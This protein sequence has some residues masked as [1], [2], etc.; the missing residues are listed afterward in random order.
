[1][2]EVITSVKQQ[3]K[4]HINFKKTATMKLKNILL[5]AILIILGV[6]GWSES[7]QEKK[8]VNPN[9]IPDELVGSWGS[10]LPEEMRG[11]VNQ[12]FRWIFDNKDPQH[13]RYEFYW[14]AT[15]PNFGT[16]VV[17]AEKGDCT[18]HLDTVFLN[19]TEFGSQQV[20]SGG[21]EFYDTT[22]WYFPGDTMFD[23]FGYDGFGIYKISVDTLLWKSPNLTGT[24]SDDEFMRF[25]REDL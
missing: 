17:S 19:P 5:I 2:I 10:D 22:K 1:L 11:P 21:M 9:T 3:L 7:E 13:C 23:S 6:S 18:V 8:S 14:I 16:V 12:L 25:I 20:K 24:A 15:L 4:N